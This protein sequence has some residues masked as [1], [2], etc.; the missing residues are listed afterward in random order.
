MKTSY[1]SRVPFGL[2]GELQLCRYPQCR[3]EGNWAGVK[4]TLDG[5]LASAPF[6]NHHAAPA[7][8]EVIDWPMTENMFVSICHV[9][10]SEEWSAGFE[11]ERPVHFLVAKDTG[12]HNAANTVTKGALVGSGRYPVVMDD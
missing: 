4:C 8:A 9:N 10:E 1:A 12:R 11:T 2:A 7:Y 5:K 3:E 6:A